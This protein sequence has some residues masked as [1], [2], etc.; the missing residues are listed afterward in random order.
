MKYLKGTAQMGIMY[1]PNHN[2]NNLE[3]FSDAD[4]AGDLET[5]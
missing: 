2:T 4:Y 3:C 1:K 5:R